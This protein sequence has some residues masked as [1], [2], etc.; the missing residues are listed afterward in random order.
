MPRLQP[1][2]L[3]EPPDFIIEALQLLADEEIWSA[4]PEYAKKMLCILWVI[5]DADN[6]YEMASILASGH[7]ATLEELLRNAGYVQAAAEKILDVIDEGD[8]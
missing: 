1:E 2:V 3:P 7:Y 6:P 4:L 8:Y 5:G